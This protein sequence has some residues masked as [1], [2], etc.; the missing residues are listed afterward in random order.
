MV[1]PL[2]FMA[3]EIE[4]TLSLKIPKLLAV[5]NTIQLQGEDQS[6]PT[7]ATSTNTLEAVVKRPETGSVS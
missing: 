2:C 5:S 6:T 1:I 4:G 7:T 3:S